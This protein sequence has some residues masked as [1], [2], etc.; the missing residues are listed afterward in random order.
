MGDRGRLRSG[1]LCPL[2]LTGLRCSMTF[3]KKFGC[4]LVLVTI[5][6]GCYCCLTSTVAEGPCRSSLGVSP[7][8]QLL[9]PDDEWCWSEMSRPLFEAMSSCVFWSLRFV[10]GGMITCEL[11]LRR[12]F[13]LSSPFYYV[14]TVSCCYYAP[15]SLL[16]SLLSLFSLPDIRPVKL[17]F[18]FKLAEKMSMPVAADLADVSDAVGPAWPSLTTELLTAWWLLVHLLSLFWA[19]FWFK[20]LQRVVV[21]LLVFCGSFW[22]S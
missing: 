4:C 1:V 10:R 9:L 2:T 18:C 16:K 13:I 14:L 12:D 7:F 15:P 22:V 8:L 19:W 21:D 3:L 17:N 11:E 6:A 20:K 5:M